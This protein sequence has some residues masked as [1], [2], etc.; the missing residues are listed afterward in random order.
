LHV[1]PEAQQAVP[2]HSWSAPQQYPDEL[3][4]QQIPQLAQK[5]TLSPKQKLDPLAEQ[6]LW[7]TSSV[8]GCA[9]TP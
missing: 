4:P 1:W 7:R 6:V 2:Q 9:C 3:D 5:L 8:T